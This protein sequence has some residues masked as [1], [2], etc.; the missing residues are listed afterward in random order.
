MDEYIRYNEMGRGCQVNF[1][2]RI[3]MNE[4]NMFFILPTNQKQIII[5][6]V[7]SCFLKSGNSNASTS[8]CFIDFYNMKNSL[9]SKTQKMHRE[10]SVSFA[11]AE[12]WGVLIMQ[13]YGRKENDVSAIP[14]KK[15]THKKIK[16]NVNV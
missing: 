11:T 5:F 10:E 16:M 7:S 4:R 3:S 9:D 1:R 6:A 14:K 13:M 8:F 12:F 2:Y 15:K